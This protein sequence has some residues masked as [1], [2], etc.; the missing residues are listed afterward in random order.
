MTNLYDMVFDGGERHSVFG[1]DPDG[2]GVRSRFTLPDDEALSM[3]LERL[4][5]GD[6]LVTLEGDSIVVGQ[7]KEAQPQGVSDNGHMTWTK[8]MVITNRYKVTEETYWQEVR[9]FIPT[10]VQMKVTKTGDD[11][12]LFEVTHTDGHKVFLVGILGVA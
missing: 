11:E 2:R 3:A 10:G 4:L 5:P 6:E 9:R 1:G 8:Q 7:I 12:A